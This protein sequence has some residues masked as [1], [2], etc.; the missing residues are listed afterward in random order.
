MQQFIEPSAFI[1]AGGKSHRFNGDKSL[2]PIEGKPIIARVTEALK[3]IFTEIFIVSDDREKYSFL[4]FEVIPDIIPGLGPLGGILTA[5]EH[6]RENRIFVFGCDMPYLCAEF[7]QFMLSL[8]V[9]HDIIV[10]GIKENLEPLHAIYSPA[11][12][13]PI[14]RMIN[15]G[16]KKITSFYTGMNVRIVSEQ[17]I[18]PFGDPR[19]LFLN[20]NYRED[21]P[22]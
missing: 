10:P 17:E 2:H 3:P 21:L 22:G 18:L 6:A 8:P 19:L 20:V 14:R 13:E 5:L 7:I 9:T 1:L 12:R 16:E 11:C 15:A 4:E